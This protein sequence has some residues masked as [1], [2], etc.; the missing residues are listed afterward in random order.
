MLH[1]Q[2]DHEALH[3]LA[4]GTTLAMA[5]AAGGD[6]SDDVLDEVEAANAAPA[7]ANAALQVTANAAAVAA[8]AHGR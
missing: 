4:R 3:A 7:A 8:A 2:T 5:A 1:L 6:L